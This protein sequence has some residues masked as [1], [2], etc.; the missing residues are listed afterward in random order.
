MV[1]IPAKSLLRK[2]RQNLASLLHVTKT[3][4]GI[5]KLKFGKLQISVSAVAAF[6]ERSRELGKISPLKL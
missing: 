3:A 6:I 4:P 1:A 5:E 2:G